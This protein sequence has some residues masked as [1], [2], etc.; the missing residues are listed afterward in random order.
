MAW[1]FWVWVDALILGQT[2]PSRDFFMGSDAQ[3]RVGST[4]LAS[5]LRLCSFAPFGRTTGCDP[6]LDGLRHLPP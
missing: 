1:K 6:L 3:A 4:Q 2:E 5:A